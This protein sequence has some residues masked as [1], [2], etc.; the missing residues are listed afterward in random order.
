VSKKSRLLK[1]VCECS[2]KIKEAA[3]FETRMDGNGEPGDGG[4]PVQ[5]NAQGLNSC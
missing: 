1:D 5:E 4:D 2:I 3:N